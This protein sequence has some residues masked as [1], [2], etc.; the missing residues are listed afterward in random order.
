MRLMTFYAHGARRIGAAMDDVVVD[1]RAAYTLHRTERGDAPA[2]ALAAALFPDD[3][4]PFIANGAES[5]SAA[6]AALA[7]AMERRSRWFEL[8]TPA[9]EPVAYRLAEVVVAPPVVRPGKVLGIGVNYRDHAAETGRQPPTEPVFFNKFA[10]S[11]VGHRGAIVHPG[12]A[13]TAKLDYEGE[14]A[15]VIGRPARHVA[16]ADALRYVYGYTV[17]NDVSARDLQYRDGQFVKGKGLDAF[18]P[19]GPWV[20]TADEVPDPQALPIRLTL[21][22]Q[23]MQAG[24]T[25]DMIFPV[26]QLISYLSRLMTLEPGDV[27][28]TGTPA[29]VGAARKPPVFLEPGDVVVVEIEGIGRLE[30]PVVGAG[31]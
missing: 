23:I 6:E 7:W 21:N 15:V 18:A 26:A 2:P 27:I 24:H 20:V 16:E 13:V 3:L 29:G 1:L 30:N 11:L 25:A 12:P 22:G 14:L 17:F 5:R 4:V 28:A 10:T 8:R 31:G 9:G 19:I